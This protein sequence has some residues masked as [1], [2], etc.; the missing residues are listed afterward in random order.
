MSVVESVAIE[1]IGIRKSFAGVEVLHGVDLTAT[2][3]SVLALLGENGAGKSTLVKILAGDYQA[4]EGQTW[5]AGEE[6]TNMTPARA[7]QLGIRM[8]FQELSDAPPL[9]V[10]ENIGLGQLPTRRGRVDWPEA[11]RQAAQVLAGLG[12]DIDTRRLVSSLRV[13][14]RQLVEIA[15]ALLGETSCLILD[16]PTAALS[17]DETERLFGSIRR[18]QDAGVAIIYITHRL[19]EVREIAD[20]VHVLRDGSTVLSGLVADHTRQEIVEAMVG[21]PLETSRKA[22]EHSF[23][24]SAPSVL[25][26]DG[27][28]AEGMFNDLS[29]EVRSQEIVAI[30]GK[31]GAGAGEVAEVIYG[32][33]NADSGTVSIDGQVVVVK[34]PA[35]AIRQGIGLVPG[36]RQRQGALMNRSVAE[37]LCAPSWSVLARHGIISGRVEAKA[38]GHW[39]DRLR[40][41]SRND[42]D[43]HIAT[44]SGG[45]QQKVLLGRWLEREVRLLILVEPTRGVDVG[46]REEIYRAVRSLTEQGLAVLVVTSDHDEV[47]QIADRAVVMLRGSIVRELSGSGLT[48]NQLVSSAGGQHD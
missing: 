32:T 41:R 18:L 21:R 46:A 2:S 10:A 8:I 24:S 34:S 33:R 14:E 38:Y 47:V 29:L 31:V 39:H 25:A 28:T 4:D 30:Y 26:L 45:N 5:F 3:G 43:Q 11:H 27:V 13:G 36:D 40:I 6:L 20:R 44:L 23:D 35:D 12:S 7:R 16:E 1:A 15:R 19:D 48:A 42:P 37:N 22:T 9:N 17:A